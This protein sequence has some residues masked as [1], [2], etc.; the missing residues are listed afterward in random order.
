MENEEIP[1]LE[2]KLKSIVGLQPPRPRG[3]ETPRDSDQTTPRQNPSVNS[4][5][6]LPV[7]NSTPRFLPPSEIAEDDEEEEEN[8]PPP[9]PEMP[10]V[11]HV[12]PLWL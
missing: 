2:Q 11:A 3:N 1:L 7:V 5:P 12:P 9:V 8:F 4:T 10:Q 6:R